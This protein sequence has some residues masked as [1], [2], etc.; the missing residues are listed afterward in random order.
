MSEL[1]RSRTLSRRPNIVL[2]LDPPVFQ[3]LEEFR[4]IKCKLTLANHGSTPAI[5]FRSDV[6]SI[7]GRALSK[8]LDE[9]EWVDDGHGGR[10]SELPS[11]L[12]PGASASCEVEGLFPIFDLP[13]ARLFTFLEFSLEFEDVDGSSYKVRQCY[14]LYNNNGLDQCSWGL[15]Y[16]ALLV[17]PAMNTLPN[18]S[19]GHMQ[20]IYE[21]AGYLPPEAWVPKEGLLS[22]LLYWFLEVA[23]RWG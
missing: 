13:L 7:P 6:V 23:S 14:D 22:K 3:G 12:P 5:R 16:D 8:K 11:V 10:I 4:K 21:R 19:T 20:V 17:G 18:P 1:V 9:C 2:T 15:N